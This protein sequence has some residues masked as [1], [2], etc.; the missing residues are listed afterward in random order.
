MFGITDVSIWLV[1]ILCIL[2]AGLCVIY[3]LV[4]WNKGAENEV[5]Q[6]QEETKWEKTDQA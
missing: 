1:F 6:I 5:S 4:N 2:S 3:G